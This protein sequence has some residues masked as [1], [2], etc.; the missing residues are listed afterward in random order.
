[1]LKLRQEALQSFGGG[2]SDIVK[3]KLSKLE[4]EIKIAKNDIKT[5]KHKVCGKKRNFKQLNEP[6]N[7]SL[8]DVFQKVEKKKF[9][10]FGK[11]Q[12][13]MQYKDSQEIVSMSE[14]LANKENTKLKVFGDTKS[15]QENKADTVRI[16][17]SLSNRKTKTSM[18][19]EASPFMSDCIIRKSRIELEQE[20]A[21][22]D[23]QKQAELDIKQLQKTKGI[24]MAFDLK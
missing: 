23:E 8:S 11:R 17:D 14:V 19:V 6:V 22:K 4:K 10:T 13:K 24:V 18:E 7:Q 9:H 21:R 3:P 20:E 16:T 1:M 15:N 12:K 5:E 2:L